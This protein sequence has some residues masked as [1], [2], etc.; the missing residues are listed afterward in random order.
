[1]LVSRKA[2][3]IGLVSAIVFLGALSFGLGRLSA[4]GQTGPQVTLCGTAPLAP[5]T[6]TANVLQGIQPA[7]I[8]ATS[9]PTNAGTYVASKNGSAYHF[10]WCS[11]AQRIREENKI[12]FATKEEAE[13]AGYR[14]ASNCK[15]L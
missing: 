12:W 4:Y 1:M 2:R 11:G 15:G 13:A 8:P 10:P 6:I 3:D 5:T 7:P 14:P 9:N